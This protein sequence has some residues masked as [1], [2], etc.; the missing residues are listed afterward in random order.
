MGGGGCYPA[1]TQWALRRLHL[2]DLKT[3]P[4]DVRKQEDLLLMFF[5]S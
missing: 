4:H 5:F 2:A 3:P 1:L